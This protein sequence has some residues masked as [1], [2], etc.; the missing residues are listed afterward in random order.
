MEKDYF[1]FTYFNF[2]KKI[3]LSFCGRISNIVG[4]KYLLISIS[5]H[6][7]PLDIELIILIWDS[8]YF[9]VY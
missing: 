5:N 9:K 7:L 8:R 2:Y 3:K 6:S 4:E 1:I